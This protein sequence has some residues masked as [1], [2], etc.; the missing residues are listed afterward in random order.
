MANVSQGMERGDVMLA[1]PNGE[2]RA[3]ERFEVDGRAE[4]YWPSAYAM[5]LHVRDVSSLGCSVFGARAPAP[6]TRVFVS[7]DLLGLPNVR[8]P[9]TAVRSGDDR[10]GSH[11]ALRF[12]VP[13]RSMAGLELLLLE[14]ARRACGRPL[15]LIV[16]RNSTQRMRAAEAARSSGTDVIF[17][18]NAAQA[19]NAVRNEAVDVLLA[20]CDPSGDAALSAVARESPRTLRVGFGRRKQ[21]EQALA[22]GSA[23]TYVD[24]PCSPKCLQ[25]I[26]DE[27]QRRG[28]A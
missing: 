10:L 18:E 3:A 5:A 20:R 9:A 17:V 4:L 11:A 27:H 1:T 28:K 2:R 14:S 13:Q 23:Q 6:G 7:L 24:D 12:E 26:L 21:V 16:D 8:L 25:R 15:L 22:M 19:L